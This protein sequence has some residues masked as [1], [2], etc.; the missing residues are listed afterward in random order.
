MHVEPHDVD[1]VIREALI[2][3]ASPEEL[4]DIYT[5]QINSQVLTAFHEAYHYWQGLRLPYLHRYAALFF[6]AMGQVFHGLA[7]AEPDWHQWD[8][9][10]RQSFPSLGTEKF[11]WFI[12]DSVFVSVS[13]TD[14][15]GGA[16]PTLALS[17]LDLLETAASL[18]EFQVDTPHD[19][20][21]PLHF[22]RWT[23]RH[24]TYRGAFDYASRALGDARLALRCTLPAINASFETT[25]PV[26]AFCYLIYR[27]VHGRHDSPAVQTFIAQNEPCRWGGLFRTFLNIE[28]F[29]EVDDSGD[30]F[31]TSYVRLD[32]DDWTN[33]TYPGAQRWG[34][35]HPMLSQKSRQWTERA[36]EDPAYHH[37][38]D[39]VGWLSS[40]QLQ[41]VLTE[42]PPIT[43]MRF[44][45][46]NGRNKVIS[47]GRIGDES[48]SALAQFM[49]IMGASRRATITYLDTDSTLCHHADCPEYAANY[50][51]GFV[52]IPA[53]WHEC[54]FPQT[55]ANLIALARP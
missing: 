10:T 30:P 14:G 44:H 45:M 12:D 48:D 52:K 36:A 7:R 31:G 40:D 1:D 8:T 13:P 19:R 15:P 6:V 46:A 33:V 11:V 54:K 50:C 38:L 24:A 21:D 49:T 16:P 26:R 20:T 53:D 55:M 4:L 42:F 47:V 3:D 9:L 35:I 17:P 23:K 51:H 18:A 28:N 34:G 27:L 37:L 32:L 22:Q 39:Q 5:T 43:V 29:D 25:D 41:T 2:R